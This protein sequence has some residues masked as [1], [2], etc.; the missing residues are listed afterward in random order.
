[1]NTVL[2]SAIF[3]KNKALFL[4]KK[5]KKEREFFLFSK[6]MK[7]RHQKI[8]KNGENKQYNFSF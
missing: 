8:N 4:Q 6:K 3:G 1:M 2:F 7:T 5:K